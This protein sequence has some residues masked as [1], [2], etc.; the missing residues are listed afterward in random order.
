MFKHTVF[1][2]PFI[3]IAIMVAIDQRDT[4]ITYGL[5]VLALLEAVFARNFAMG[6]NRYL[7]QDI[8]AKNE[9]TKNRPSVDGR[10]SSRT[11]ILFIT[12]N[13]IAF[14]VTAFY[15]NTTAFYASLPILIILGAYSYMKRFTYLA[16][17]FLGVCLGL[18]PIAGD[19]AI[20]QTIHWWSIFLGLGVMFWVGGFDILYALQDAEFDKTEGLY[21]IPARF[22]V[23]HSLLI[24]KTL[25]LLTLLFWG[26]F[27]YTTTLGIGG[28]IGLIIAGAMLFYEHKIIHNNLEKIDKAFFTVNGYLGIIFFVCVAI[29]LLLKSH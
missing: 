24:A 13:A 1:A 6:F 11:Q 25:H 9:R 27:V 17:L 21:S 8:D 23:A 29:S 15:I 14:V 28:I 16:H 20:S 10:V 4:P 5:I 22:G 26:A 18:A 7:D 19:I 12:C 2:L 3:G